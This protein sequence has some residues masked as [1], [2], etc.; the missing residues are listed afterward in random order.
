MSWARAREGKIIPTKSKNNFHIWRINKWLFV[1]IKLVL[2]IGTVRIALSAGL[3]FINSRQ[4]AHMH[5]FLD[6]D[7]RSRVRSLRNEVRAASVANLRIIIIR[8]NV[9][10][11]EHYSKYYFISLVLFPFRFVDDIIFRYSRRHENFSFFWLYTIKKCNLLRHLR[12]TQS[13]VDKSVG[14]SKISVCALLMKKIS[15]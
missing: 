12:Q 7:T 8:I 10:G 5:T 15:A 6:M 3:L 4:V 2:L 11:R 13:N 1:L 9:C 14:F